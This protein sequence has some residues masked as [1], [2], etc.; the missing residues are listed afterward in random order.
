ML[1][2]RPV[3]IAKPFAQV[4]PVFPVVNSSIKKLIIDFMCFTLFIDNIFSNEIAIRV[5]KSNLII[6][7]NKLSRISFTAEFQL[8]LVVFI[9]PGIRV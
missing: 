1:C 6:G 7:N 8:S 4:S 5:E 3:C 2:F 9:D